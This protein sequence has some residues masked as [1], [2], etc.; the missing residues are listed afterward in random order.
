MGPSSDRRS[1]A[2][3]HHSTRAV[4]TKRT[5]CSNLGS[6]QS[7]GSPTPTIDGG[8]PGLTELT[9]STQP[10]KPPELSQ[11]LF[12]AQ[13]PPKRSFAEV[14]A[15]SHSSKVPQTASHKLFLADSP[16]PSIGVV[17][18][19][20]KGPPLVFTNVET[21]ALAV[22]F[23]LALVEKFSHGKPQFRYLHRLIV[24]LGVKG[25]FTVS[26]INAKHVL[27]CLSN[28]SDFSY[29]WLKRIWYIQGFPMQ[30]FK[31]SPTFTPAQE[32]SLIPVWIC[33]PELP[34]HLFHKDALFAVANM[35]G[36]PLQIDDCTFNQS[37]LS[38]ARIGIEIDL[39]KPLVEGFNIQINGVTIHQK[40]EY[41]Q[42]PK[43]C[44][45]CKHVGHDDLECY[46]MDNCPSPPP[47]AKKSKGKETMG[48]EEQVVTGK[49]KAF[50][51]G[52]CS[53]NRYSTNLSNDNVDSGKHGKHDE[54][55]DNIMANDELVDN[56]V[57]NIISIDVANTTCEDGK[58]D[59]DE[60]LVTNA[61]PLKISDSTCSTNH[62]P[63]DIDSA[64]QLLQEL[65]SLDRLPRNQFVV[66]GIP[67][68]LIKTTQVEIR[69]MKQRSTSCGPRIKTNRI[70]KKK[71]N[72]QNS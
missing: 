46:T 40:V 44:N 24:G 31:W 60:S 54:H 18:T 66:D 15:P 16:P 63:A 56:I 64:E 72:I 52:D 36:T 3:H 25:A 37:K 11:Q 69:V 62:N 30:I 12:S 48:T 49:A 34:A 10:V 13:N 68:Y 14:V 47:R 2:D 50:E 7:L 55:D 57:E 9:R 67:E 5:I 4:M 39:T 17:L 6:D 61:M 1:Q 20:E 32:S 42:L 70:N 26:M 53:K 27:I 41:E 38:K 59:E 51:R 19:D 23:Q 58:M 65:A 22:P 28:E 33:F 71:G 43:Y 21:E 35:I 45:L 29:M 8:L